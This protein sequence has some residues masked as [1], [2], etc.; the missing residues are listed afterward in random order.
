MS[1]YHLQQ[2]DTIVLPPGEPELIAPPDIHGFLNSR[3]WSEVSNTPADRFSNVA[4]GRN[5][6][7]WEQA[8]ACEFYEF[9]TLGGR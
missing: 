6:F 8:M 9:I 5:G 4:K 7:T 1:T 2:G 3:G